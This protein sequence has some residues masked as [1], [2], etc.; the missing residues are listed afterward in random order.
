[1]I[2]SVSKKY[3][4]ALVDAIDSKDI[5]GV[6]DILKFLSN[7]FN[8]EQFKY[9][10]N[11]PMINKDKKES[12]I[13]SLI[14]VRDKKIINFIRLL[15]IK[16]RLNEIPF[17]YNEL[18]KYVNIGN[19]EYELIIYSSFDIDSKSQEY[20]RSELSKRLGVSLFATKKYMEMEG[21]KLF[22]DGISL[23][24]SFLKN[25]FSN[26]LKKYILKAF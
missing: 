21:I 26:S 20:I 15:N 18:Q 3:T 19:N 10:I 5:S 12:F 23:E 4:K 11:S 6:I 25:G 8:N 14:N 22:V 2:S 9:I 13:F 24:T 7:C 16:N 17:I 1:M